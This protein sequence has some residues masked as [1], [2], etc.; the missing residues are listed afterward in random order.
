MAAISLRNMFSAAVAAMI[1][2]LSACGGG[3]SGGEGDQTPTPIVVTTPPTTVVPDPATPVTVPPVPVVLTTQA[4]ASAPAETSPVLR[5]AIRS[6]QSPAP[7]ASPSVSFAVGGIAKALPLSATTSTVRVITGTQLMNFV[8][9]AIPSLFPEHAIDREIT[10]GG[11]VYQWRWYSNGNIIAVDSNGNIY[12]LGPYVGSDTVAHLFGTLTQ[13]TCIVD[14]EMC[15]PLVV[16]SLVVPQ[17]G[18]VNV[19]LSGTVI[20]VPFDRPVVC[21]GGSTTDTFGAIQGTMTCSTTA[22]S[23]TVTIVTAELPENALITVTLGGFRSVENIEMVSYSWSFTTVKK[24]VVVPVVKVVTANNHSGFYG[25][26]GANAVSII[27]PSIKAVG[28]SVLPSVPGYLFV[29]HIDID[30]GKGTIYVGAGLTWVLH[31]VDAKTGVALPSFVIDSVAA[32]SYGHGIRGIAHS[33][34]AVCIVTG[35][36]QQTTYSYYWQ[37]RLI[38]FDPITGNKVFNSNG[39]NNFVG[40]ATMIPTKLLYSATRGKF[41]VIVATDAGRFEESTTG[42]NGR[43]GFKPGTPGMVVEIDATT[44]Q[45]GRTWNVG[46][47]PLDAEIV[48]NTLMVVN[49]GD[50]SLSK[51][52]LSVAATANAVTT[53]DWKNTFTGLA[54]PTNIKVDLERGVYYVSDWENSVR[55]M[56]LA[57]DQQDGRIV[58][59]DVPWGMGI[60][61][62][63]LWV[64]APKKA[65]WNPTG[66]S[67]YR[68][69]RAT[70]LVEETIVVGNVMPTAVAIYDNTKP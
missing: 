43:D 9:G 50:K 46:S 17:N 53:I 51:I 62:G 21:P 24:P 58:I 20:T 12:G 15:R 27:D 40:D 44:Y 11:V 4:I 26:R 70:L 34:K 29:N 13:F 54:N 18:A 14:A 28:Q 22:T 16:G 69:N 61:A 32:G 7:V 35:I 49:A 8:E 41:Y 2:S 36:W 6:G 45:K 31:R 5:S 47:M 25:D 23:A 3:G 39:Q 19:P 57:T 38:C 59:G 33:D 64:A 52:D 67:V 60:A 42:S 10:G 63:S 56:R 55:V 66:D 1:L 30:S 48:G 65:V 68:V 37:N